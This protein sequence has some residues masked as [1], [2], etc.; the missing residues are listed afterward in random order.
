LRLESLEDQRLQ[1]LPWLS[2]S[3]SVI[4]EEISFRTPTP[5]FRQS[6]D[7]TKIGTVYQFPDTQSLFLIL[8]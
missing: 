7:I 8:S 2:T 5:F 3:K 4:P 1:A 6:I